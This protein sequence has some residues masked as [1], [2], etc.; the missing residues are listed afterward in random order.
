[1]KGLG[2][3][4]VGLHHLQLGQGKKDG[5]LY[6]PTSYRPSNPTPL[7]LTLHGAGANGISECSAV[8]PG[9]AKGT[10]AL[11]ARWRNNCTRGAH[12]IAQQRGRRHGGHCDRR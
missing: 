10:R 9:G 11:A 1:M 4:P 3:M 2:S 5:V 8:G 6:V 7:V 12:G